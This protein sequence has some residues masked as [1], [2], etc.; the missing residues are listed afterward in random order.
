MD[1]FDTSGSFKS[2]YVFKTEFNL[3]YTFYFQWLQ[4]TDVILKIWKN[5]IQ[6]NINNNNSL[7][8]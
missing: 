6:N 4:L 5:I 7:T 3:N 8:E 1:L 2:C